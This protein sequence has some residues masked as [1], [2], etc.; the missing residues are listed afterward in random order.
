MIFS[1]NTIITPFLR[2][3]LEFLGLDED[4]VD[5]GSAIADA[6]S[7]FRWRL[8]LEHARPV[9]KI[10]LSWPKHMPRLPCP[11]RYHSRQLC[12]R[13]TNP[14]RKF[15]ETLNLETGERSIFASDDD[16][17]TPRKLFALSD[18]YVVQ[19]A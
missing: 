2:E 15:V 4:G 17:L 6:M 19:V 16:D 8:G 13:N 3:T 9:K 11:I 7:Y 1:C 12:Y 5:I 14:H 18:R 10:F